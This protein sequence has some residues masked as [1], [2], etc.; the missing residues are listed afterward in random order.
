M[1]KR[2]KERVSCVYKL[3]KIVAITLSVVKNLRDL[4]F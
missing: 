2:V 1:K 3:M 4:F